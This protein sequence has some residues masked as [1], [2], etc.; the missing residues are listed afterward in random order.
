MS[1]TPPMTFWFA[2]TFSQLL[3]SLRN[4]GRSLQ[5]IC[6]ILSSSSIPSL[7]NTLCLAGI[8]LTPH[9]ARLVTPP[10][11]H[12]QSCI[13]SCAYIRTQTYIRSPCHRQLLFMG[14][15]LICGRN[16]LSRHIHTHLLSFVAEG[17]HNI[18]TRD[19]RR[20]ECPCSSKAQWSRTAHGQ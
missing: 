7:Q 18:K 1:F 17:R 4:S 5:K 11:K 6:Q 19:W 13:I 20:R 9:D 15:D 10:C 16:Q 3:E 2:A 12:V 14:T 8:M